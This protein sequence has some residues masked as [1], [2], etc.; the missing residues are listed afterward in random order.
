MA[1]KLRAGV[2]AMEAH[3]RIAEFVIKLAFDVL[4]IEFFRKGVVDV[5]KG[6]GI[7]RDAGADI[8]G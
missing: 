8:L 6:N 7:L 1:K 4:L 5:E 2:A 3:K